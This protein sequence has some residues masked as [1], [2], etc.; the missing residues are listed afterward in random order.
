[1]MFIKGIQH[2]L[3]RSW[4]GIG[5]LLKP[6]FHHVQGVV[7]IALH[8]E[9][10]VSML[11]KNRLSDG[12]LAADRIDGDQPSSDCQTCEQRRNSGNLIGFAVYGYLT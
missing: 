4:Y 5:M 2:G 12:F 3:Q 7:L 10:L 8:C 6:G 9:Y 11:I 1:M